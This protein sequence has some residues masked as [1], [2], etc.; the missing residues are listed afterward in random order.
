MAVSVYIPTNSAS[1]LLFLHILSS[2]Y[3]L[4]FLM[5]VI[6]TGVRWYLI[7][8]LIC[9]SLIMSHVDHLLMCLLAIYMSSLKKFCLDLL[10]HIL[11]GLLVFLILSCMNFLHVLEINPLIAAAFAII[12]HFEGCLF[13]LFI[14]SFAVQKLLSFI[15][16]I[17]L[18]LFLF[19][20]V[21]EVGVKTQ[22]TTCQSNLEK[23]KHS[24]RNQPPWLQITL[25]S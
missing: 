25:Q 21:L 7:V 3:C 17:C 9:I 12:S 16:S 8:V 2:I 5:I 20:L 19:L 11:I 1:G 22:T 10:N 4:Y 18:F 6:V 13:I 24:W 23:E 14:I 15:W